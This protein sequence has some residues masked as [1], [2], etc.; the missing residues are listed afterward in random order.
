MDGK[1]SLLTSKPETVIPVT[2]RQAQ[3]DRGFSLL[4]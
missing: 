2:L 4:C 3:G 1:L